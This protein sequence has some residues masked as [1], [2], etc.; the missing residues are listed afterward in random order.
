MDP[1]DRLGPKLGLPSS[2]TGPMMAPKL[3]CHLCCRRSRS[4]WAPSAFLQRARLGSLPVLWLLLTMARTAMA[5]AFADK[6]A[7]STALDDYCS[8]AA[9]AEATHGPIGGWDVSAVTDM[10]AWYQ[11][12]HAKPLLTPISTRGT[13]ARSHRCR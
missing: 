3:S 9:T 8:N 12:L 4:S 11:M 1:T 5:A 10:I 7:L 6:A 2:R 13:S